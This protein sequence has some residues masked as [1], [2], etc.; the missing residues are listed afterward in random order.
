MVAQ[1]PIVKSPR[2]EERG[3]LIMDGGRAASFQRAKGKDAIST[4]HVSTTDLGGEE[5]LGDF[6]EDFPEKVGG[7]SRRPNT[8]GFP[9]AATI[10]LL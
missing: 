4:D 1:M 8:T 3:I 9:C 5:I 10:S 6:R 7:D 2:S